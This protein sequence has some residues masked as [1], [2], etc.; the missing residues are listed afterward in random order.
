[1][2][3]RVERLLD[4]A[5]GDVI[6]VDYR[7]RRHDGAY[8]WLRA[9]DTVFARDAAGKVTQVLGM[10]EDVTER[11]QAEE[12]LRRSEAIYR[13][14]A[15]ANLFGVGFGTSTGEVTFVNDEMLRMMGRTRA[16]F[17]A[18]CINWAA[19]LAPEFRE[20]V[21]VEA[22]RVLVEESASGYEAAF[23]RPDGGRTPYIAAAALVEPGEDYHVSIALDLTTIRAAEAALRESEARFRTMADETPVIIWAHDAAGGIEF[24][25]RAYTEFFGVTEAEVRGPSWQPLVHPDD[26]EAYVSAFLTA[27]HDGALFHAEARVRRADGDWRWIES[28]GAPRLA[29]NGELLGMVGS[30]L[31]I[32]ERK[33]ATAFLEQRQREFESLAEHLPDIVARFDRTLRHTY[34]NAAAIEAIGLQREDFLGR[35]NAELGFPPDLVRLWDERS[36]AAFATGEEQHFAFTL[37]GPHGVRSFEARVVPE[38]DPGAAIETVLAVVTDVTERVRAEAE[39]GAFLDALAHDVK[40]PLGAAKG[41]AQLARRQLSRGL[42]DPAK[43]ETSLA[44]IDAAVNAATRLI[45][46]LLDVAHLR[47]GRSLQLRLAP[48]DLGALVQA[49]AEETRQRSPVHEVRVDTESPVLVGTWDAERLGRVLGNLLD[50]AVKYSPA[51][52]EI[53]VRAGRAED[54]SGTWAEVAVT[55]QGLGIPEEDLARVFERF[56]R[57]TNVARIAG[58][59]IGLSGAKQIVEQ[60]GGTIAVA[61]V[62]GRGSTFMVRLPL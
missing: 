55:D 31:D 25:N 44:G 62:E 4:L 13:R 6:E 18:G 10:A 37:E 3:S 20:P 16:E 11:K 47:A 7:L 61:S 21:A 29:A 32:T 58:T 39:R 54:E 34:V 60:H 57:G 22:Q 36:R 14:L 9:R 40:N 12:A 26:V 19:A 27:L 8:R 49:C 46:D 41:R 28:F 43:L 59:G 52:G 50:N 24:V 5:D 35:T 33:W 1:M 30:S 42:T 53:L 38:G 51:G 56:H 23:L 2:T 45:D 48:T 17:E 15:E